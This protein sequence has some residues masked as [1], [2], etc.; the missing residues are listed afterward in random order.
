MDKEANWGILLNSFFARFSGIC[1]LS[2]G[3]FH[4]K[5]DIYLLNAMLSIAF[6]WSTSELIVIRLSVA[7]HMSRMSKINPISYNYIVLEMKFTMQTF[8]QT[9]TFVTQTVCVS[10]AQNSQLKNRHHRYSLIDQRVWACALTERMISKMVGCFWNFMCWN[11]LKCDVSVI[12]NSYCCRCCCCW[13][14]LKL[15]YVRWWKRWRNEMHVL[16]V[17]IESPCVCVLSLI[18]FLT[19]IQY[20]IKGFVTRWR[21]QIAAH[22][23]F[24]RCTK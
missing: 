24:V 21:R 22:E 18:L 20:V 3:L 23:P 11:R 19:R 9:R 7:Q 10:I 6:T 1:C 13:C 16:S 2:D 4:P 8:M 12:I 17:N 5:N 15:I 14:W